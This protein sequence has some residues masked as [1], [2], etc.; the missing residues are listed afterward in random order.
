[1]KDCC[2]GAICP[3]ALLTQTLVCERSRHLTELFCLIGYVRVSKGDKK[4]NVAQ[5]AALEAAA[6]SASSRKHLQ[7]DA[8]IGSASTTCCADCALDRVSS[9]LK[10]ILHNMDKIGDAGADFRSLT[11]SIDTATSAGRMMQMV[12]SFAKF[13]L[14]YISPVQFE[15]N[16]SE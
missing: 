7:A 5:A 9:N 1:M 10:D 3:R 13:E 14:D 16:A 12:G 15:R 6:A 8:W 11:K 4:S 2:D